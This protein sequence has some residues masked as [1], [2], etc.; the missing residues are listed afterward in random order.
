MVFIDI[1]RIH[2]HRHVLHGHHEN[3]LNIMHRHLPKELAVPQKHFGTQASRRRRLPVQM[4]C[5]I[6]QSD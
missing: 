5:R 2:D 1:N 3:R 4:G 6:D